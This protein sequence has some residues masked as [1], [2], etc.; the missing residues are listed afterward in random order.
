MLE[1]LEVY[2]FE[3]CLRTVYELYRQSDPLIQILTKYRADVSSV[4]SIACIILFKSIL[5]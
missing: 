4:L 3:Q 2:S 5:F 1:M